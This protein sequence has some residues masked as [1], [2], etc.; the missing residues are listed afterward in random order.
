M[1]DIA[2]SSNTERT[3]RNELYDDIRVQTLRLSDVSTDPYGDIP[4][5]EAI[6]PFSR[7]LADPQYR[8]RPVHIYSRHWYEL[9]G[10]PQAAVMYEQRQKGT[11]YYLRLRTATEQDNEVAV[12]DYAVKADVPGRSVNW[13]D[14]WFSKETGRLVLRDDKKPPTYLERVNE[15][16]KSMSMRGVDIEPGNFNPVTPEDF[17]NAKMRL[18]KVA[19]ILSKLSQK[20]QVEDLVLYPQALQSYIA[21]PYTYSLFSPRIDQFSSE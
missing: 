4:E 13:I 16:G 19:T 8:L 2:E 17:E 5:A 15:I 10:Q 6:S 9:N 11:G 3:I 7:V 18:L 1:I 20:T 12:S 21:R 14:M